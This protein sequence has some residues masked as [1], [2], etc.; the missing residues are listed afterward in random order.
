[1]RKAILRS[2][3]LLLLTAALVPPAGASAQSDPR[4]VAAVRSAQEGQSDSARIAVQQLLAKTSPSDTLYPQILYTSAIIAND[5]AEMRRQL[6]RLTVEFPVS[7]WV[8]DALV[9]LVQLDYATRQLEGAA[10]N[11]ERLAVD[12]SASPLLPQAAYWAGRT[13]FD[14]KKNAEACRWLADGIAHDRDD[15]ELQNQLNYLYQ[16]CDIGPET[17]AADSTPRS[18]VESSP[19]PAPQPAP[20]APVASS[21]QSRFRVQVAAVG[22]AAAADALAKKV[23]VLGYSTVAVPE[24]GLYKVRAGNFPTRAAA[25]DASDAL[26]TKL[27]GSPFVV[28]DK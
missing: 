19:A 24:S 6:Q 28:S 21:A 20:T 3:G 8:D 22:T 15:V 25:Q 26:K 2:W 12:F 9:R 4:L 16:R 5:A 23:Q 17:A 7:G 11:L 13:Y 1:M 10:R 18:G 27:G 14:L